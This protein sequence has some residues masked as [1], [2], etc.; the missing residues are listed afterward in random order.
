MG[1]KR[2]LPRELLTDE[3]S[4]ALLAQCDDSAVGLRNRALILLLEGT[5]C[6]ISEVL[7]LEPRDVEWAEETVHVRHGNGGHERVIPASPEALVATRSWLE[8]RAGHGIPGDAVVC[9]GLHGRPL[10]APYVRRLLSGLGERAGILKRVH[11][12]GLRYRFTA[13]LVRHGV[14]ITSMSYVLGHQSIA[15]TY[16]HLRQLGL[17]HALDDVQRA[18]DA[19]DRFADGHQSA[20]FELPPGPLARSGPSGRHPDLQKRDRGKA[21]GRKSA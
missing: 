2:T 8:A 17:D 19:K 6:R 16:E 20:E 1:T 15:S 12:H 9:C 21:A 3:E 13:R 14:V 7:A 10:S 5:G 4:D 18:L 11:A